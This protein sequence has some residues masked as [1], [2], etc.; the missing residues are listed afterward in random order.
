VIG[1][2]AAAESTDGA[3][4][5]SVEDEVAP[6]HRGFALLAVISILIGTRDLWTESVTV[7]ALL[8]L[9]LSACY[10]GILGLAALALVVRTPSSMVRVDIGIL[11][12][13]AVHA[14]AGPG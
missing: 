11:V 6:W 10:A 3:V 8:V 4:R 9:I 14:I 12:L 5:G 7:S 13:A 2:T 1:R